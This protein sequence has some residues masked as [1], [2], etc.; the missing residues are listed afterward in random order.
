MSWHEAGEL[1]ASTSDDTNVML[2]N[3]NE[4]REAIPVNGERFQIVNGRHSGSARLCRPLHTIRTSKN[5][6]LLSANDFSDW[7]QHVPNRTLVVKIQVTG[8]MYLELFSW[9]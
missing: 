2:W 6:R 9:N 7:R 1:L 5:V 3:I 4:L 8:I